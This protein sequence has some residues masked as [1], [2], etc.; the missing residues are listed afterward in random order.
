VLTLPFFIWLKKN[1]SL[2]TYRT[3]RLLVV[4]VLM[5]AAGCKKPA[6]PEF[7]GYENFRMD[8]VGLENTVLAT[9]VKL[10]N[11]N[12]FPLQVKSA[13]IDVYIND[14]FLGHSSIDSLITLPAKDT[15]F[16]PL[17]LT[18]SSKGLLSNA[19][20][21]WMNPEVKVRIKGTAKA[22][23]SGFFINVPIDYE[24]MQRIEL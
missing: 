9:R 21:V 11:P 24:G 20:K 18:A 6:N 7:I 5:I 19:F 16:V 13:G 15:S 1:L 3:Y 10:Y 22:G 23:R 2:K 14:N 4:L 17:R 12:G 8:K